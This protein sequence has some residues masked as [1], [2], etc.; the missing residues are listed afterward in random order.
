MCYIFNGFLLRLDVCININSKIWQCS[1]SCF[2][3]TQM[4]FPFFPKTRLV[5]NKTVKKNRH[6]VCC[7]NKGLHSQTSF[8]GNWIFP[9]KSGK[10]SVQNVRD[11][12]LLC[13]DIV[14]PFGTVYFPSCFSPEKK[15]G[16]PQSKNFLVLFKTFLIRNGIRIKTNELEEAFAE[17][18]EKRSNNSLTMRIS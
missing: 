14:L 16:I 7:Y 8:P 12:P 6:W 2:M 9:K 3:H 4:Y 5:E 18:F 15:S 17:L 10:S 1:V 13:P 11:H